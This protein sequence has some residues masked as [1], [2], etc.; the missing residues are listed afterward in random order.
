MGV[1]VTRIRVEQIAAAEELPKNLVMC[2]EDPAMLADVINALADRYGQQLKQR[3]IDGNTLRA[4]VVVLVNGRS[5]AG[6][7]G[8]AT[9]LADG[10]NI[11]FTYMIYGG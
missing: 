5:V 9:R 11:F 7:Q 10:D 1:R 8:L 4:G 6:L 3:L 2:I